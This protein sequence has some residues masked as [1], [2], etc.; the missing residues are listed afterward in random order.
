MELQSV[1]VEKAYVAN[2]E[3][4]TTS[5]INT[6]TNKVITTIPVQFPNGV[7]VTPDGKMYM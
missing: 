4:N 6:K 2:Q 5:V 7:A 3:S 1:R